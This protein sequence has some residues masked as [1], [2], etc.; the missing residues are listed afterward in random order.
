MRT[1]TALVHVDF[2]DHGT[3]APA[4]ANADYAVSTV[5]AC[6]ADLRASSVAESDLLIIFGGPI[7]VYDQQAYPF[8]AAELDLIRTRLAHKR[9]TLGICLG[10]QLIAAA[11]GA[12]VYPGAHGKEIG[13]SALQAG[14]DA[15]LHPEFSELL[16][17]GVEVLHWHGDTFDLPAGAHHLAATA[18][19]SSQAFA[20]ERHALGLQFHP[21][22]T[23]RGLERW[24]VGHACELGHAKV[25][26]SQLRKQSETLA[27]KLESA[28]GRFWQRWLAQL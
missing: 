16:A 7:G 20:L 15:S 24:Y 17:P 22:V 10:A 5:N 28:A 23:T 3:L 4:L 26:V 13:W 12:S 6:T 19:Y 2:E 21:E 11:T 1:A 14:S 9:P 27:P 8:L 18:A 25:D